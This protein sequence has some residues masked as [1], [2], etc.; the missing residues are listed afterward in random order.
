M[1]DDDDDAQYRYQE[2][3]EL[4]SRWPR[5]IQHP[6][7]AHDRERN[8]RIEDLHMQR[9]RVL[10]APERQHALQGGTEQAAQDD[11]SCRSANSRPLAPNLGPHER[12]EERD[13]DEPTPERQG[14]RGDVIPERA[15][16]GRIARPEGRSEREEQIGHQHARTRGADG[17]QHRLCVMRAGA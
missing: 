15:A 14:H 3:A 2:S 1:A 16:D 17:V 12:Q 13:G 4:L 5:A 9:D 10:E 6:H 11:R 8:G 7:R